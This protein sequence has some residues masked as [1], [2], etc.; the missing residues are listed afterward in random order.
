MQNGYSYTL[1]SPPQCPAFHQYTCIYM[2]RARILL[3]VLPCSQQHSVSPDENTVT[4]TIYNQAKWIEMPPQLKVG[5]YFY[6]R[7]INW[8]TSPAWLLVQCLSQRKHYMSAIYV[9][10]KCIQMPPQFKV[11]TYIEQECCKNSCLLVV[12]SQSYRKHCY[13]SHLR[14]GKVDSNACIE[15]ERCQKSCRLVVQCQC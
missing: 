6:K 5:I 2:Y 7:A 1:R 15:R 13:C 10:A 8:N 3:E 4:L 14:L 9:Q 11:G 12:Q